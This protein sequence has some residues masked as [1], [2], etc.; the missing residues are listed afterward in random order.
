VQ[1]KLSTITSQPSSRP[2]SS[3][4]RK[5]PKTSIDAVSRFLKSTKRSH[6]LHLSSGLCK[7]ARDVLCYLESYSFVG[8]LSDNKQVS[9]AI[10]APFI[11]RYG[12]LCPGP[13][14]EN[15]SYGQFTPQAI[16]T[17][18]LGNKSPDAHGSRSNLFSSEVRV[19]GIAAGP[20]P[21]LAHCV[22]LIMCSNYFDVIST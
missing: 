14:L 13:V 20:H 17:Q 6:R 4:S 15:I 1:F 21:S 9:D 8:G 11:H 3:G 22:V 19:C 10:C 18:W 2:T 12:Q 7:V 5:T 16:L